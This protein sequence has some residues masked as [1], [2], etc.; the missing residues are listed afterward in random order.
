MMATRCHKQS[1][2]AGGS[3]APCLEVGQGQGE[4]GWGGGGWVSRGAL[5][6][7]IQ[8]I[9]GNLEGRRE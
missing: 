2:R 8:C 4:W 3:Y 6:I 5:Y 9:M 1:G 7:W